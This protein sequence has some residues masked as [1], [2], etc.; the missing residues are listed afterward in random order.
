MILENVVR[1]AYAEPLQFSNLSGTT[2]INSLNGTAGA[3]IPFPFRG[4]HASPLPLQTISAN[5]SSQAS[6]S[7]N[8]SSSSQDDQDFYQGLHNP[9]SES[10]LFSFIQQGYEPRIVFGLLASDLIFY[11]EKGE[12][13]I[14]ND[15]KRWRDGYLPFQQVVDLLVSDG[16]MNIEDI[17]TEKQIGPSLSAA[18]LEQPQVLAALLAPADKAPRVSMKNGRYSLVKDTSQFRVCFRPRTAN[19]QIDFGQVTDIDRF[20]FLRNFKISPSDICGAK[21]KEESKD[22]N[23]VA[24]KFHPR[25][26]AAGFIYLGKIAAY[27]LGLNPDVG[28]EDTGLRTDATNRYF[29][30]KVDR[31]PPPPEWLTVAHEGA[32]YGIGL[33]PRGLHDGSSR[34]LALLKDLMA[35]ESVAKS[36]PAPLVATL[37]GG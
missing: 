13:I 34:I 25:S 28:R 20:R 21:Q 6:L 22:A 23:K 30:F 1:A 37:V 2:G 35:L 15:P 16:G 31:N 18:R 29:L 11:N 8:F 32:Y 24:I 17:S 7:N 9:L 14:S 5:I 12:D 19:G 33:D 26:A 36:Q 3:T 4:G 10:T 27:Q